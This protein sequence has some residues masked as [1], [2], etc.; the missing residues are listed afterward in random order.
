MRWNFTLLASKTGGGGAANTGGATS[1]TAF[2]A[3]HMSG[4][5]INFKFGDTKSIFYLLDT[6]G[7]VAIG[8]AE[9]SFEN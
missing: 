8:N 6:T 4:G 2:P 5:R 9:R 1:H 7:P 3:I